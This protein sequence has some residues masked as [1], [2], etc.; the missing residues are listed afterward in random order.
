MEL[1]HSLNF[2]CL[3]G[4]IVSNSDKYLLKLHD[5][6]YCALLLG[7]HYRQAGLIYGDVRVWVEIIIITLLHALFACPC[8]GQNY[9]GVA[10]NR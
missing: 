3:M 8:Y 9:G 10:E 1:V 5:H 2:I 6:T 7:A 4:S